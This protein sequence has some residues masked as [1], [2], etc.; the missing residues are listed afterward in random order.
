MQEF[1]MLNYYVATSLNVDHSLAADSFMMAFNFITKTHKP[2]GPGG[3]WKPG[4]PGPPTPP[5]EPGL[6]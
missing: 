4:P 3:P 6:P 2:I 1:C 5:G